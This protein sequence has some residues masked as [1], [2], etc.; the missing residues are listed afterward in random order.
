MDIHAPHFSI[1]LKNHQANTFQKMKVFRLQV[2]N[3]LTERN[4]MED[5]K[6]TMLGSHFGF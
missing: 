6:C 3:Q 2:T 1:F 4:K 5:Q